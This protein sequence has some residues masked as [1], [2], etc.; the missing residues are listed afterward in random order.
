VISPYYS[1]NY[2]AGRESNKVVKSDAYGLP[3]L[4]WR[5][6]PRGRKIALVAYRLKFSFYN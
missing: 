5:R 2:A 6:S 4:R 1:G 3:A